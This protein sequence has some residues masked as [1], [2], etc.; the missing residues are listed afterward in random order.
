MEVADSVCLPSNLPTIY[1]DPCACDSGYATGLADE[2]NAIHNSSS[3]AV[4]LRRRNWLADTTAG[5]C[6][7]FSSFSGNTSS[8]SGPGAANALSKKY[9]KQKRKSSDCMM[10]VTELSVTTWQTFEKGE[11]A[12]LFNRCRYWAVEAVQ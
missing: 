9:K 6:L 5:P 10:D 7:A 1:I 3:H 11:T 2:N 4:K 8:F 12:V